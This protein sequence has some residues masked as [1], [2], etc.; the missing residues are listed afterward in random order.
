MASDA[1]FRPD[2]EGL[3]GLAILVVVGFHGELSGFSGGFVGVDV[4]FV[5][6]GYLITGLLHRELTT[7]GTLAFSRFYARRARR[8][9]PASITVLLA[10]LGLAVTVLPP[11]PTNGLAKVS[12]AALTSL[13]NLWFLRGAMDYFAE[14]ATRSPLLH[15]WSLAVEEQFYLVWPCLLWLL[16]RGLKQARLRIAT[17]MLLSVVS[18]VACLWVTPNNQALGFFGTP[19][20]AWEFGIGGLACFVPRAGA[21]SRRIGSWL[22]LL[23]VAISSVCFSH[24]RLF[25]DERALVPVIGTALLL[26]SLAPDNTLGAG[27]LLCTAPLRFLGRVSYPWYLW[28]WPLLTL[29]A[30][31]FSY[32][33]P[34]PLYAIGLSLLLAWLTYRYIEQPLRYGALTR[35]PSSRNLLIALGATVVACVLSLGAYLC[36]RHVLRSKVQTAIAKVHVAKDPLHKRDHI[37]EYLNVAAKPERLGDPAG[38]RSLV[39]IGDSHGLQWLPALDELGR[40]DGWQ[41]HSYLKIVCPAV[42]LPPLPNARLKRKYDECNR[43]REAVMRRIEAEAPDAIVLASGQFYAAAHALRRGE[44]VSLAAWEAAHARSFA[45]LN[46]LGDVPVI[47]IRDNPTPGINIPRCVSEATWRNDGQ[48]SEEGCM[49]RRDEVLNAEVFDAMR[50]TAQPYGHIRFVDLSDFYCDSVH[51]QATHD[52]LLVYKDT[53]HLSPAFLGT[54]KAEAMDRVRAALRLSKPRREPAHAHGP[55]A[56]RNSRDAAAER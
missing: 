5:L 4:F 8:L 24:E 1:K 13:S 41:L 51:C 7:T 16:Y 17:I 53:N 33:T 21:W 19:F 22:S 37:D 47:L 42:D 36:T 46:R 39:L 48:L 26:W 27:R 9:L 6:S 55:G 2:I 52:G 14:D 12:L 54:L 18:C 50:R 40:T 23:A 45:R 56:G 29:P 30:L 20:R 10:T 38:T 34:H 43:W 49:M 31:S 11:L 15:T 28:H 44:S 35:L 32:P 25:P 3:R